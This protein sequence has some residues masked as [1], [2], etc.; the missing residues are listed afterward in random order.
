M[1]GSS[2]SAHAAPGVEGRGPAKA[3][4]QEGPAKAGPQEG[5][6]KA[7][8]QEKARR[9][10]GGKKQPPKTVSYRNNLETKLLREI[11]LRSFLR[12][13]LAASEEAGALVPLFLSPVGKPL[14][15][16]A[17]ARRG[18]AHRTVM[19]LPA[20]QLRAPDEH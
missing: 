7:G 16:N 18:G 8:P 1:S 19:R 20:G 12:R 3:G 10:P 13:V 17:C 2:L 4:P 6:A 9:R 15:D 14:G 5:S 11:Q